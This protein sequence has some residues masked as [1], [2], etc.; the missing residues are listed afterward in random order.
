MWF[1]LWQEGQCGATQSKCKP[2]DSHWWNA[3]QMLVREVTTSPL[4]TRELIIN[5]SCPELL[6]AK[7]ETH[8][9]RLTPICFDVFIVFDLWSE[10]TAF[11]IYLRIN[12]TIS[13]P[14]L[15]TWQ[16]APLTLTYI[17]YSIPC[18][19]LIA[20]QYWIIGN[21]I[22]ESWQIHEQFWLWT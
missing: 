8:A 17:V 22:T 6:A 20:F 15:S 12:L 19:P 16:S 4:S 1:L 14:N 5:R 13:P 18:R 10:I 3:R 2:Q 9:W 21:S 11:K 7:R